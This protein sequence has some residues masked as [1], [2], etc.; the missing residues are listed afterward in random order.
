MDANI[1]TRKPL[2]HVSEGV[3]SFLCAP[4]IRDPSELSRYDAVFMGV[5][6]EGR[7]T[8]CDHLRCADAPEAAR[9][10]SA[11]YGGFLP[12]LE[13]D[14]FDTL[15][16]GDFGDVEVNPESAAETYARI[17]T[18]AKSIFRSG[19]VPVTFG[20]DHGVTFPM[21]K[22]LSEISGGPVGIVHLDAHFDNL[23]FP[24]GDIFARCSFVQRLYGL[25]SFAPGKL[26]HVGIR[27][28]RNTRIQYEMARNQGSM[29]LTSHEVRQIGIEAAFQKALEIAW[30]DTRAVYITVCS[31]V[32]D[33]ACNPGGSP[34]SLGFTPWELSDFLYRSGKAGVA[35]FDFM[36]VYPSRD[37]NCVSSHISVWMAL[38]LLAGMAVNRSGR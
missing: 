29:I 14:I 32:M 33:A 7:S 5:P 19:A 30:K 8:W 34:D 21:I 36:E 35:G 27:G 24:E 15:S 37:P 31:D 25:E 26:V 2:P 11:R 1:Y 22:A 3:P 28:P 4:V 10:A 38:Y 20:G 12:E 17:E 9:R 16:I 6:W 23:P 13:M 18:K